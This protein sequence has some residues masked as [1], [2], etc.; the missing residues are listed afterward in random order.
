MQLRRLLRHTPV[1]R[2]ELAAQM[3]LERHHLLLLVHQH[4]IRLG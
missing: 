3:R 1:L 2:R 4:A